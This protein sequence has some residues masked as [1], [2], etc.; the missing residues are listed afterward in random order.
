MKRKYT[1]VLE[2]ESGN[3]TTIYLGD[4]AGYNYYLTINEKEIVYTVDSS[5]IS[6]MEFDLDSLI[7]EDRDTEIE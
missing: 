1:I 3:V 4:G 6:A 5:V 2:D 7:E